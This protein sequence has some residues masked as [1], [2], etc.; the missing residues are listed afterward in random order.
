MPKLSNI[1]HEMYAYNLAS[2]QNQTDAYE[3]AGFTRS[4]ANASVMARRPEI[5]ARVDE[6]VAERQG[7]TSAMTTNADLHHKESVDEAAQSGNVTREYVVTELME[8]MK[9][10]REAGQF[11]ASN[12]CLELL[13][14]EIGMFQEASAGKNAVKEEQEKLEAAK[15]QEAIPFDKL[16][17]FLSNINYQG[18]PIDPLTLKPVELKPARVKKDAANDHAG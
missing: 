17:D 10:A 1:R 7:R 14:K 15:K 11:S 9:L 6:L 13:G 5:R 18:P 3:N 16:N 12:K 8:N 2:G 4:N